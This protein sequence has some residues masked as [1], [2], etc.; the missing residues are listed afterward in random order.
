MQILYPD[1]RQVPCKRL[2]EHVC[3]IND[4]LCLYFSASGFLHHRADYIRLV[5]LLHLRGNE[6]VCLWPVRGVDNRVFH[7]KAFGR[8]LADDRNVEIPIQDHRKRPRNR[9]CAHDDGMRHLL[10]FSGQHLPLTDA[11]TMLFVCHNERQIPEP[12]ALLDQGMCS[13][14]DLRFSILNQ[15]AGLA[16]FPRL[17]G[18]CQQ[19]RSDRQPG[20]LHQLHE[21][22]IVLPRKNLRRSHDGPLHPCSRRLDQRQERDDG[23]PAAHISLYESGHHFLLRKFLRYFLPD[24]LLGSSELIG[25]RPDS[26]SRLQSFRNHIAVRLRC[27]SFPQLFEQQNEIEK[28]LKNQ[29][30]S[31]VLKLIFAL[32]KM[33]GPDGF[34]NRRQTIPYPDPLRK[35]IHRK[36]KRVFSKK[37]L[38]ECLSE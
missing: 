6:S 3:I 14:N 2:P 25:Q 15:T 34:P 26:R 4:I 29:T 7:R 36:I 21:A 8:P 20:L 16:F 30:M 31:G 11:K 38:T 27:S 9:S 19:D 18:A 33:N 28:F 17:Q 12:D 24:L 10:C 37:H 13:D 35:R 22:V 5:T 23:L 32:R 1:I